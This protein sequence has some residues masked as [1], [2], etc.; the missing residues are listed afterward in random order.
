MLY[1]WMILLLRFEYTLPKYAS[2]DMLHL[3]I[4]IVNYNRKLKSSKFIKQCVLCIYIFLIH[5]LQVKYYLPVTQV[6]AQQNTSFL[7]AISCLS[8]PFFINTTAS[9]YWQNST[10]FW[11]TAVWH[12]DWHSLEQLNIHRN[13]PFQLFFQ[14]HKL[15][16][17]CL[18]IM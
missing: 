1:V 13:F 10:C 15:N 3:Q 12:E 8:F 7:Q 5:L 2:W 4:S 14:I 16:S 18:Q 9:Q 6:R 11:L 17:H